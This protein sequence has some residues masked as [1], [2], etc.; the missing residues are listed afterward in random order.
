MIIPNT[1]STKREKQKF[2]EDKNGADMAI[3]IKG[4]DDLEFCNFFF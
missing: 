2:E 4:N 1:S 3:S